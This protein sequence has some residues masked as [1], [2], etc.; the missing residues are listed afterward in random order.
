MTGRERAEAALKRGTPD[1]VPVFELLIDPGVIRGICPECSYVEFAEQYVLDIVLTGTPSANYRME[2]IDEKSRTYRDEWGVARQFSEQMVPF[3]MGGPIKTPED[4]KSYKPP[5]PIDPF[6]FI[7]LIKLL[8]NFKGEKLVG[9]HVHDAFSYPTYLR[10]MDNLLMDL[11]ERSG[12][13]HDLVKLGVEHTKALMKK[14]RILGAELFVFGDDYAGNTGPLMSPKH[15]EEFFLPGLREVVAYANEIGAY[16]IKH[17]DGNI[18]PI[19]EMIVDTGINGLHPLDP[20][21][22]MNIKEVKE[23]YG[24]RICVIGSIDT[25]KL[26]SESSPQE[27]EEE[28]RKAIVELAPGGGYIISSANSI[29]AKVRPE[30]YAA[31]LRAVKKYGNYRH[32]GLE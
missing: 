23:K 4:L 1:R 13:V 16:T 11:I 10:G 28:V 21:A 20:E 15:F 29:H 26:L 30:N 3:P 19:I 18:M 32:L 9:M 22:G 27:V 6:R 14:A 2:P 12:L 31:M 17:T 7:G 24:D 5:D 25:G 8:E